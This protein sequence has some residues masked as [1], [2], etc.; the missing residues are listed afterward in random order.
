MA[1]IDISRNHTLGKDE[2]KN[3]ANAILERMKGSA[4]IKGT[5]NGDVFNIEAPAKGTFRVTDNTVR[6]ELDLPLMMRPL[7]G[8]IESRINQELDRSLT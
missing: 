4:G 3:R 7:K 2:A 5:W 8:T 6:I 1:T